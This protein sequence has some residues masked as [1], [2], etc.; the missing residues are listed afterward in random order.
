[1]KPYSVFE[2]VKPIGVRAGKIAPWF[3]QPGGGIQYML[4][5]LVDKLLDPSVGVLRRLQ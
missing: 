5:D 2:V 3:D 4:P 1:M